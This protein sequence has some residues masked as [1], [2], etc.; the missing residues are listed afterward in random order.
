MNN[1]QR[2]PSGSRFF[3]L[4]RGNRQGRDTAFPPVSGDNKRRQVGVT[5]TTRILKQS[6]MA[7]G[8]AVVSVAAQAQTLVTLYWPMNDGDIKSYS[9]H[10]NGA[11]VSCTLQF[12]ED[13]SY[14]PPRFDLEIA[15]DQVIS[16][17]LCFGYTNGARTLLNYSQKALGIRLYL[18]PTW[19]ILDDDL[20]ARGGS[21]TSSL[22]ACVPGITNIRVSATVTFAQAGTVTVPAGTYLDCRSLTLTVNAAGIGGS[23]QAFILAPNVGPIKV[24]VMNSRLAPLGWLLLT[25]GTVAGIDVTH[26]ANQPPPV[27]SVKLSGQGTVSPNL[28]GKPLQVGSSNTMTAKAGAG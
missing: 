17:S 15:S 6:L 1:Q 13:N 5:N 7:A 9:N 24:G 8:L 18:E 2:N 27:L 22:L 3:F 14:Y 28:N 23:G 11:E 20:L 10:L 4:L 26:F 12:S 16:G 19:R 21:R 25:G